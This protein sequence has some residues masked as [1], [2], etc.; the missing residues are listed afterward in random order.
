L[1]EGGLV[2]ILDEEQNGG[3]HSLWKELSLGKGRRTEGKLHFVK[4][5]ALIL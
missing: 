3:G 1:F 5:L 4:G 2:R